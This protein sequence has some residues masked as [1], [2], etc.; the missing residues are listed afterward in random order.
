MKKSFQLSAGQLS[1]RGQKKIIYANAAPIN[2]HLSMAILAVNA[3]GP[4]LT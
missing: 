2:S 1:G 3:A 4:S